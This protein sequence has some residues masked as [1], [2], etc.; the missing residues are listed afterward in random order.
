MHESRVNIWTNPTPFNSNTTVNGPTIDLLADYTGTHIYGTS[1][2]GLPVQ[3][4]AYDVVPGTGTGGKLVIKAQESPDGTNWTDL[5]T[6]GAIELDANG[7]F[8]VD[9]TGRPGLSRAKI[10]GRIKATERY[11][12]LAVTSTGLSGGRSVKVKAYVS[13]GT[14][15]HND[16]RVV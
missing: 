16:G 2:Y 10:T 6:I 13:D 12:R 15:A 5:Q 1:L 11:A 7:D 3:V 14:N 4:W 9:G 8:I